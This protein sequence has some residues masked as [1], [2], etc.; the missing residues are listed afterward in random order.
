LQSNFRQAE[1]RNSEAGQAENRYVKIRREFH[2]AAQ[3]QI[4][5]ENEK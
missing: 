5:K 1:R 4:E 3:T 2:Q